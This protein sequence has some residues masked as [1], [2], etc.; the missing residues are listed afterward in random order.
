ME[1]SG[2]RMAAMLA[3]IR[4]ASL[5]PPKRVERTSGSR[6]RVGGSAVGS[7]AV[8]V[9][10][11]TLHFRSWLSL[12]SMIMVLLLLLLEVLTWGIVD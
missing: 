6:V 3:F 10:F 2:E 9:E 8:V 5:G 1:G 4:S 12:G 7:L 11:S